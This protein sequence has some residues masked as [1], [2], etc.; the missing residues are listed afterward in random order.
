MLDGRVPDALNGEAEILLSPSELDPEIPRGAER[1]ARADRHAE[2]HDQVIRQPLGV[3][4]EPGEQ[5]QAPA[6]GRSS[7]A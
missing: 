1:R 6:G 2:P 3:S 5:V 4:G 7:A